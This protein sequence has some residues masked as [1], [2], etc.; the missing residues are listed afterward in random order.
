M[1]PHSQDPGCGGRRPG[2]SPRTHFHPGKGGQA[3]TE[4]A[5]TRQCPAFTT[6]SAN[7]RPAPP[8]PAR[9]H[10]PPLRPKP[11]RASRRPSAA[12]PGRGAALPL[13]P[14]G[15]A[16]SAA[17]AT[18]SPRGRGH[19]R[20]AGRAAPPVGTRAVPLRRAASEAQRRLGGLAAGGT[21]IRATGLATATAPRSVPSP[22]DA[23]LAA[24]GKRS[25]AGKDL[26]GT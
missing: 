21:D 24:A 16:G 2:P 11:S 17:G 9:R 20:R 25:R 18:A 1:S 23:R 6:A 15:R 13:R 14:V 4:T 3:G 7:H 26:R 8:G 19:A 5:A 22:Q 10:R 12:T